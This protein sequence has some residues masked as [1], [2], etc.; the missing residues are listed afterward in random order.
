MF[1]LVF[2]ALTWLF[3]FLVSAGQEDQH[4][5]LLNVNSSFF[6]TVPWITIGV[7][8]CLFMHGFSLS[9]IQLRYEFITPEKKGQLES[10]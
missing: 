10:L 4:T 2:Y 7:V 8:I 9:N 3:F 5:G 1:P 6:R